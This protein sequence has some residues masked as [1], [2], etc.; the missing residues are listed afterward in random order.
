[1]TTSLALDNT[2]WDLKLDSSGNIEVISDKQA[3]L[4]DVSSAIQTWIGEI[5]YDLQ[6]GLPYDRGILGNQ[7]E[8]PIFCSLAREAGLKVPGVADVQIFPNQLN[9]KR[10][11]NGYV[12]VQFEDGEVQRVGF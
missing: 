3:T 8:I 9:S 2:N 1:M 7:N 12:V 5:W 6:Q 10:Q 11:L 4:Q